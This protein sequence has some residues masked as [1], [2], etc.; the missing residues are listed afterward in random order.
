MGE[1]AFYAAIAGMEEQAFLQ[2]IAEDPDAAQALIA[3]QTN[4]VSPLVPTSAPKH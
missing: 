4:G 3:H 2:L 1:V